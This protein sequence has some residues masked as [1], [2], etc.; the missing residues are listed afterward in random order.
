MALNLTKETANIT[1]SLIG[2]NIWEQFPIIVGTPLYDAYHTALKEQV[3]NRIEYY[4]TEYDMWTE[5]TIYPSAEGLSIFLRDITEK[6]LAEIK[7]KDAEEKYRT[8]VETSQE[9]ILIRDTKGIIT[10]V[11]DYLTNMLKENREYLIGLP[12]LSL[13]SKENLKIM[14]VNM[15]RRNQGFTD[16]YDLTLP[17]RDGS[18]ITVYIKS[19]PYHE[20]GVFAGSLSTITDIT[21]IKTK[22]IELKKLSEDLRSLSTYLQDIREEE[23]KKIAMEIHDELGQ[24]LAILKM[25]A[26]WIS[27]QIETDNIK[28][29][30]RLT[31]FNKITD[32]TVKTSRRLYNH[33]YP[34]MIYDIGLS[35]AINW[36]ADSYLKPGNIDF[37]INTN[38]SETIYPEH[39]NLWLILYRVYQE[40]ITN[41]IRY[42]NA[43]TVVVDLH[44]NDNQ[45]ELNVIDDGIGFK[46]NEVQTSC[47]SR[48]LTYS[49]FVN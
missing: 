15:E 36:H 45:I 16:T 12:L 46:V 34:Q 3:S 14:Q 31:Q 19:T 37:I 13:F 29:K 25:D 33:L 49:G 47:P 1:N 26:T 42:A 7:Q 28:L 44:L 20:K 18:V 22:E 11:N 2:E 35:G 40:C 5:Q 41:I 48:K 23:R 17:L 43:R 27:K 30:E 4:Y 38:L 8:I 6:K 24:N 21:D 10:Y 32:D 39:H 9:G